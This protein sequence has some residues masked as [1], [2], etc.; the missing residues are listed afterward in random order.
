M[1]DTAGWRAALDGIDHALDLVE[2]DLAAGQLSDRSVDAFGPLA[3]PA[4]PL[5]ADL[6]PR[7][8]AVLARMQA[9]EHAVA[10]RRDG[11]A[12]ALRRARPRTATRPPVYLDDRA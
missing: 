1:A 12:T 6:A 3:R 11:V 8:R 2:S 10:E 7:A 5:P 9:L 4:A